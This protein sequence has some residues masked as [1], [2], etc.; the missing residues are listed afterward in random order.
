MTTAAGVI[1]GSVLDFNSS[2]RRRASGTGPM[3]IHTPT[4]RQTEEQQRRTHQEGEPCQGI[5]SRAEGDKN[6][7][8]SGRWPRLASAVEWRAGEVKLPSPRWQRL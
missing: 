3:T 4:P 7:G 8:R 5:R 6:I 1:Q 2:V